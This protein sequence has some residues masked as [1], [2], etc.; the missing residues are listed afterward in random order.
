MVPTV[1]VRRGLESSQAM[2]AKRII[3][4]LDVDN[5]RVVKGVRFQ[6]LRDAGDPAELAALYDQE[7]ADEVVF[8][9]ITASSDHRP[10]LLDAVARTADAVFIPLPAGGRRPSAA[11]MPDP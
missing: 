10:I 5:G 7:G 9:D 11:P 6:N 1:A 4:C 2:T 3:P 8:L